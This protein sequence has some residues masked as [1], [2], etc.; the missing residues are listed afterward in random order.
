MPTYCRTKYISYSTMIR[1]LHRLTGTGQTVLSF[2]WQASWW[3]GSTSPSQPCST[4]TRC[5][6]TNKL[7][8]VWRTRYYVVPFRVL[9]SVAR[10]SHHINALLQIGSVFYLLNVISFRFHSNIGGYFMFSAIQS[11]LAQTRLPCKT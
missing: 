1:H 2:V 8:L 6:F 4:L 3:L 5:T 10:H 11:N 9:V 7:G